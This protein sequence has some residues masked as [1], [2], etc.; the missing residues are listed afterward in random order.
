MNRRIERAHRRKQAHA[1]ERGERERARWIWACDELTIESATRE[2][3]SWELDARSR[4]VSE[5]AWKDRS[6]T[7]GARALSELRR[8]VRN[9]NNNGDALRSRCIAVVI[10]RGWSSELDAQLINSVQGVIL[11]SSAMVRAS[12][13]V[14]FEAQL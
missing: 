2:I 13:A 11:R 1:I 10:V 7:V 9:D 12:I 8:A 6:R 5:S 14:S 3:A 4:R